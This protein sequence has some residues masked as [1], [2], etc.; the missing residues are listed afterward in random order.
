MKRVAAAVGEGSLVIRSVHQ[1]LAA[2]PAKWRAGTR[3]ELRDRAE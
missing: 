1:Y 2:V 3:V